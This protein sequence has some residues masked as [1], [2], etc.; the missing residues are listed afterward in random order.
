MRSE[1]VWIDEGPS[2]RR[3]DQSGVRSKGTGRS[4]KGGRREVRAL[5]SVVDEFVSVLGARASAR[6]IRRYEA[7]LQAFEAF[8][9]DE[10]RKILS[11][12]AKEYA[13]VSAVHE[14]LGL[15]LYRAGQW[16]R[17]AQEIETALQLNP[18]WIFNHHVLA[19]CHRAL[20]NHGRVSE[21]WKEVS[22][23]SPNPEI[24]AEAR[25]VYAG[26]LADQGRMQDALHVLSRQAAD[27]KRAEEHHIRQW[28]VIGDLHDRMGNVIEARRFFERVMAH[29]PGFADVVERLAALGS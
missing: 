5:E 15:C 29:E 21:L 11:P 23:S 16:K 19:D 7:A 2:R 20:G 8:R 26:S 13:D 10:A 24:M 18:T 22:E 4:Q 17:A 14:M 6:A 1:E 12:M 25:I 3:R 9:Y 27:V 28:Y